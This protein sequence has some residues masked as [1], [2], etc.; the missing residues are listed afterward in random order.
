MRNKHTKKNVVESLLKFRM[1][2]L[3]PE[4]VGRENKVG[5]SE[6]I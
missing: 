2:I 6:S 3:S 4:L 5:S 1:K